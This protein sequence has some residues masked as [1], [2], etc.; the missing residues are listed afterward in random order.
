MRTETVENERLVSLGN[1]E[2]PRQTCVI[3]RAFR[4]SA[5]SAV[6]A[7]YEHNLSACLCNACR[8]RSHA[9]LC[10]ELNGD[11]SFL[12]GIL[13]IVD[14]LS[15]ILDRINIVMRRRRYKSDACR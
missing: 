14:Q 15:K 7:G 10:N 1:T 6:K 4:S 11:A 13:E 9:C 8:D 3:D 5:R 2:L 12:V